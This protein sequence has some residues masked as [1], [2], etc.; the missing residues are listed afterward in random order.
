MKL[1]LRL[2]LTTTDRDRPFDTGVFEAD[3]RSLLSAAEQKDKSD[4]SGPAGF[5]RSH[6]AS[7]PVAWVRDFLRSV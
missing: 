7:L 4:S 5:L 3:S 1:R 2:R 6:L